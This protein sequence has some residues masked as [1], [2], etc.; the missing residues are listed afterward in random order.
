[1]KPV[2]IDRISEDVIRERRIREWPVWE[3]EVSRFDWE[4]EGDEECLVLEGLVEVETASGTFTIRE[5]DFVTFRKGLKCTWDVRKPIR[6][7]YNFP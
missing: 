6:K 4:Y 3:K 1:M 2:E 5:G 7:H